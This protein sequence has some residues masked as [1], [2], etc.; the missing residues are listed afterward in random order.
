MVSKDFW[1]YQRFHFHFL[2]RFFVLRWLIE[3]KTVAM[4]S[5]NNDSET[6]NPDPSMIEETTDKAIT[7]EE[8][9]DQA[10]DKVTFKLVLM[11]T[12]VSFT[13]L[14][15][16]SGTYLTV[17]TGQIPYNEW[18]CKSQKCFD[19]KDKAEPSKDFYSYNTMCD[20]DLVAGTDF[21]WTS[22]RSSFSTEWGFY[23][24]TESKLSL[25]SSVLFLGT[26]I[27][28]LCSSGLFE[29]IGRKRGALVGS[30]LCLVCVAASSVAP[31]YAVLFTLRIL[32]GFGLSITNM[33][34]YCWIA[35]LVPNSLRNPV[36]C[37]FT[38]SGWTTGFLALIGISYYV[39]KWQYVYALVACMDAVAIIPFFLPILPESPKFTLMKGKIGEVKKTLRLLATLCNNK[40]SFEN[41]DFLYE[42]R[43]RDQS[44]REQIK[45][46]KTHP[47]MLKETL[48][49]MSV[50]FMVALVSYSYQFGWSKIGKDLYSIY[51]FASLGEAIAFIVYW[52][53]CKWLGRRKGT[54]FFFLLIIVMN[55]LAMLNI[56][57]TE[58]WSLEHIASMIGSIGAG[59]AFTMIYLYTGELAPT[60]HRGMIF[61]LSS[62]CARIGSFIGPNVNLLYG[63]TDRR[64]PLALF[65]GLSFLACVAVFFL[66]DTTDR[67]VPE[68]PFD[69]EEL[70]RKMGKMEEDLKRDGR[71]DTEACFVASNRACKESF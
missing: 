42:K 66:P 20:N 13:I 59:A 12:A 21:E 52:P 49:G 50:W 8:A 24:K 35:E 9:I 64:V 31:N 33:G 6:N 41:S 57:F 45:D 56:K 36:G 46:F 53:C 65:A 25:M 62:C 61:C 71:K 37:L 43:E 27:G 28:L 3:T 19:L 5:T 14:N 15:T 26:F 16:A 18:K 68:T 70:S 55:A 40:I 48:L 38:L 51:C 67:S 54:M 32:Y 17:F 4:V 22:K 11:L 39:H 30:I 7:I 63:V 34:S 44:Y 10:V 29:K 58:M 47:I 60:T 2:I 1:H 69:V 23:C